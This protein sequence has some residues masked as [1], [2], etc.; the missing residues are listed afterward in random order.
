MHKKARIAGFFVP[1]GWCWK[2][3]GFASW[4]EFQND[5]QVFVIA[6]KS[7]YF[8]MKNQRNLPVCSLNEQFRVTA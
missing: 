8:S 4:P 1:Q 3:S 5:I 6:E 7:G 2:K